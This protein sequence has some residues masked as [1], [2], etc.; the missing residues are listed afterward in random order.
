MNRFHPRCPVQI[1]SNR[2]AHTDVRTVSDQIFGAMPVA[3]KPIH[4]CHSIG[5]R[6]GMDNSSSGQIFSGVRFVWIYIIIQM[7]V[8]HFHTTHRCRWGSIPRSPMTMKMPRMTTDPQEYKWDPDLFSQLLRP[9]ES[10][11][12]RSDGVS[13]PVIWTNMSNFSFRQS[14]SQPAL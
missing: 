12:G 10:L 14:S 1:A 4:A 9:L 3:L 11:R 6:H 7:I 5:F 13:V 2:W 8:P